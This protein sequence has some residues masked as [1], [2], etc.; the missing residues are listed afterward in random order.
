[1]P[2]NDI[3]LRELV[4]FLEQP[5]RGFLRQRLR[6]RLPDDDEGLADT[7]PAELRG[8]PEWDIGNRLL[9]HRLRGG[10]PGAFWDAEWRRGTLPPFQ[11]GTA[12]RNRVDDTVERLV[13]AA[14][15]VHAGPAET[16]DIAVGLGGGRR[17]TGT[18]TGVHQGAGGAGRALVQT[19]YSRLGPRQRIAAWVRLLAAAAHFPSEPWRAVSTGR[20]QFRR[21][22][23][24]SE[25]TPPADPLAI[26][27]GLAELRDRGL[28]EPLPIAAGA[29][30]A[31][32][33]RMVG[34]AAVPDALDAAA[35]EWGGNFG[36][37]SER[38]LRFVFGPSPDFAVLLGDVADPGSSRFA[39]LAR[40]LWDPLLA[41]E[42]LGVP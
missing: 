10:E 11:L 18:L 3:D 16:V 32:A 25:L 27:A 19:T 20:G 17:L 6:V 31:Y 29:S 38:H 28:C 4:D 21:P 41:A 42:T 37:R 14:Q 30:S 33:A 1:L 12:V 24:R 34:G 36:D 15:P 5:V 35:K 7:L 2:P 26:L 13:R 39:R 9:A 40:Q 22:A 8:L 23:W